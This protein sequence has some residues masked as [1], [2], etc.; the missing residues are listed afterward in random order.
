MM[1]LK[2]LIQDS[3]RVNPIAFLTLIIALISISFSPIFI[4]ISEI[5]LGANGTV[6][7]RLVYLSFSERK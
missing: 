5:E 3:K 2:L 6:F 1:Q 4:R 7:N